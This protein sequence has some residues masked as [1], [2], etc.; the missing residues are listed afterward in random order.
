MASFGH[1]AVGLLTGRLHGGG[2]TGEGVGAGPAGAGPGRPCS[3][4][5]MAAFAALALLPDADVLLVTLGACDAGACGHRGA[6][7]SLPLAI[8]IGL[9]GGL[10][11]RRLRWPV[12][13]TVLATTVAVGSHA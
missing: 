2:G 4:T 11:A 12:L 1:V 7:H 5:T 13:K 9:L 6:S 10:V 8:V 3:W